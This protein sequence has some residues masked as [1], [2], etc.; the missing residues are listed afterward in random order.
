MSLIIHSAE[1]LSKSGL[2]YVGHQ[3]T[4]GFPS[5]AEDYLENILDLNEVVV[6]NPVSTFYGRVNG[7]SMKDAGAEDGDLLVIDKSL[8]YRDGA[9]AVC[10]INGE[11]TLKRIMKSGNRVFLMPANPEYEP[12]EVKEDDEFAVWGIVT[13]IVKKAF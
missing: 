13:Y 6:K 2:P 11:F 10:C 5:P 3:V 1:T 12:I 8:E 7:N 4:A 9:M